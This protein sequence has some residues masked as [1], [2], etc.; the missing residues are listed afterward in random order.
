MACP[1]VKTPTTLKSD[2]K[3]LD[4]TPLANPHEYRMLVG[5]L[6]YMSVTRPDITYALNLSSQFIQSPTASHLIDSQK[7]FTISCSRSTP[8]QGIVLSLVKSFQLTDS[9]WAGCPFIR[10]STSGFYVFWGNNLVSWSSTKQP[11]VARSST[12]AKYRL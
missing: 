5:S 8:T 2:F 12:E 4:G 11:T 9:D 1:I 6:Q 10:R 3:S 7:N